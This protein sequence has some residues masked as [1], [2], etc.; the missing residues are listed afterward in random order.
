MKRQKRMQPRPL[1]PPARRAPPLHGPY[2]I[3]I[4]ARARLSVLLRFFLCFARIWFFM[5]GSYSEK[6]REK[7]S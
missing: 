2:L 5:G 6:K 4:R 1:G 7:K 3:Y